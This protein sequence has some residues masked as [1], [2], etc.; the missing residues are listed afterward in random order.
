MRYILTHEH[1]TSHLHAAR[2]SLWPLVMLVLALLAAI[3]WMA[4]TPKSAAAADEE[5]KASDTM[6]VT[7]SWT[8]AGV[9]D[10]YLNGKSLRNTKAD[11][12]S[13]PDETGQEF[14]AEAEIKV[15]DT[16]TVGARRGER[17][18]FKLA[19]LDARQ[20]WLWQT[21]VTNW[22]VMAVDARTKKW[23]M[24]ATASRARTTPPTVPQKEFPSGNSFGK[25]TTEW[26]DP[27]WY[28]EAPGC[29]FVCKLTNRCKYARI[30]LDAWAQR[31][32]VQF[33][34]NDNDLTGLRFDALDGSARNKSFPQPLRLTLLFPK[35]Q[36]IHGAVVSFGDHTGTFQWQVECADDRKDMAAKS[37]SYKRV[38]EPHVTRDRQTVDIL[39]KTPVTAA[40]WQLSAKSD[41]G[42]GSVAVRRIDLLVPLD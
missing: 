39:L 8:C 19:I 35:E 2:R 17:C 9:A 7:I 22:K 12:I 40:C 41:S 13:R 11:F 26:A 10:V 42:K 36:E 32:K 15:G 33:L 30:P 6:K 25:P 3:A 24:P 37:G 20:R 14:S 16:I 4:L 31:G 34:A 27:I 5:E 38:I 23:Y 21:D 1:G 18:G 29:Y 28:Q